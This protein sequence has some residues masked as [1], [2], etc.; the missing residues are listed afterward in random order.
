MDT[1]GRHD[2]LALT[3]TRMYSSENGI[4]ASIFEKKGA[5]FPQFRR[6]GRI[7]RPKRLDVALCKRH[8]KHYTWSILLLEKSKERTEG[9]KRGESVCTHS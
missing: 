7:R 3:H 4:I 1:T 8:F 2:R 6:R 9:R 5:T